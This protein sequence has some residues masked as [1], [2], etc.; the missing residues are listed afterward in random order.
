MLNCCIEHKKKREQLHKG[1]TG[2]IDSPPDSPYHGPSTSQIARTL[3]H[4]GGVNDQNNQSDGASA[5]TNQ[6]GAQGEEL[7]CF[8]RSVNSD[9]SSDDEYFECAQSDDEANSVEKDVN[10]VT[11]NQSDVG[12]Q[13]VT[14]G[15]QPESEMDCDNGNNSQNQENNS[16]AGS[17]T[18]ENSSMTGSQTQENCSMIGSQTRDSTSRMSVQSESM[19]KETFSYKPEGRLAPFQE[20]HLINCDEKMFI[21]ITQEPAPMTE[22]MLEEHAEILAKYVNIFFFI[23]SKSIGLNIF[24][25]KCMYMLHIQD[26]K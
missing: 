24:Y 10:T 2:E 12:E 26:T 25:C 6:S 16:M 1:Y 18:Q 23:K 9:N 17:Q 11:E 22:D 3:S 8:N 13:D 14:T 20:L 15:N 5:N 7:S 21:P 19:Y 4:E